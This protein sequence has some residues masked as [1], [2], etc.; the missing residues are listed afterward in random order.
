MNPEHISTSQLLGSFRA[1]HWRALIGTVFISL[2]TIAGA[3][4]WTG[5]KLA[6]TQSLANHAELMGTIAQLQAKLEATQLRSEV[7][8][9]SS[10][11]WRD[12]SQ[13]LQEELSQ[14]NVEISRL[15]SQLERANNCSFI[16]EQIRATRIEMNGTGSMVVF[17]ATKEWDE[18]QKAR[19]AVLEKR[20]EGYQKQ[21]S[22]CNK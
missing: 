4:Y 14:K 5:Q 8:E 6:E 9:S 15:S 2:T 20:I 1:N 21:L 10:V 13:K 3:G 7:F 19:R 18:K 11:Q 12:N 22:T 17:E 16:H